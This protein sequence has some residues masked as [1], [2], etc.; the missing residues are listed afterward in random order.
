MPPMGHPLPPLQN[1]APP[2]LKNKPPSLKSEAP[3]QEMISRK[4]QKKSETVINICVSIIMFQL[5][6]CD[7]L[8]WSIQ[9]F[10]KK[11]KQF[12][13]KYYIT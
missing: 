10:V 3:F 11:V 1:E 13:R 7:F 8:T 12:V 2:H 4:K 5:H 6:E 9:N